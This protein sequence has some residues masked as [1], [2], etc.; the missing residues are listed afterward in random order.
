MNPPYRDPEKTKKLEEAIRIG[1]IARQTGS[2]GVY[3]Y[4]LTQLGQKQW[5]LEK[6]G[7]NINI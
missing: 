2:D 3:T 7:V 4:F 5:M 6:F 1:L